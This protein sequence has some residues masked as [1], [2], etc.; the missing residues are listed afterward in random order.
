MGVEDNFQSW[1]SGVPYELAFW[2]NLYRWD[3]TFDGVLNCWSRLGKEIQLEGMDARQFLSAHDN[4]VVLD[5]GCGMTF[6]NG[7][8]LR[9]AQGLKKLNVRYIDPLAVFYREIKHRHHRDVPDV[10]F[11]MMENLTATVE[12]NTATLVIIQNALD[13]SAH[14]LQGVLSALDALHVGGCLYLHHHPNEAET[15]HYKGFHKFNICLN[16]RNQ[17]VIWNKEERII[18]DDVIAPFATIESHTLDNGYI[19]SLLR[20]TA[21][22]NPPLPKPSAECL[23]VMQM[24]SGQRPMGRSF[25]ATLKFK[26]RYGWYNAIQFFVQALSYEDRMRLRRLLYRS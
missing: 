13:H 17:F 5:V 20:K 22:L 6:A 8:M 14:P 26:L 18:V 7:D 1:L 19:V 15:E 2:N 4:P 11:G 10:E 21:P 12:P 25:S 24:L 3:R 16:D 9:T 23:E